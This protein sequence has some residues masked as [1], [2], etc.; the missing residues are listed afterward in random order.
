MSDIVELNSVVTASLIEVL[1]IPV[2]NIVNINGQAIPALGPYES[3]A[4]FTVVDEDSDLT[5]AGTRVDWDTLRRDAVTYMY[6]D[7]GVD[8][9]QNFVINFEFKI[10][11]TDIDA[12]GNIIYVGNTIGTLQDVIDASDGLAMWSYGSGIGENLQF[13]LKDFAG[14]VSAEIYSD[15]GT[16][17]NLLYCTLSRSGDLLVFEMFSDEA[18]ETEI[19]TVVYGDASISDAYRYIGCVGNRDDSA[20]P[21]DTFTGYLQSLEIIETNYDGGEPYEDLETY[22]LVNGENKL[23][24]Y[25]TTIAWS[26]LDQDDAFYCY[27]DFGADYFE[28]Y[29]VEWHTNM[30]KSTHATSQVVLLAFG[31]DIGTWN[32]FNTQDDGI[33]FDWYWQVNVTNFRL[34][35]FNGDVQDIY[36][37]PHV[38]F[39]K[40]WYR[41]ERVGT[42]TTVSLFSDPERETL[43]TSVN[44]TSAAT[45]Y[46][47]M[48]A[49]N[50]R[51]AGAADPCWGHSRDFN[52]ISHV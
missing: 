7:Y 34:R 49:L 21:S 17:S 44:V 23:S 47:Y 19:A 35:D 26:D 30:F 10:D 40:H 29:V 37:G 15:G 32:I 36:A 41:M 51:D 33:I 4:T 18:R 2:A 46:R 3:F 22:T 11:H 25:G 12:G 6:K 31:N 8:Y 45:K 39:W 20:Q 1:G 48:Y 5:V 38:S 9:F 50:S 42:L 14:A 28:D 24:V 52:I 43:I 16:S 13:R 27:Y